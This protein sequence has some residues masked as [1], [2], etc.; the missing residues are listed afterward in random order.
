MN[1]TYKQIEDYYKAVTKYWEDY[2]RDWTKYFEEH[3]QL[4]K[5]LK[6]V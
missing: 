3:Y 1:T 2:F 5:L 6:K 4:N